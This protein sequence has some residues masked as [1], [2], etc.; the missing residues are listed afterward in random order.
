MRKQCCGGEK[1]KPWVKTHK[2]GSEQHK[3]EGEQKVGEGL[4]RKEFSGSNKQ[5]SSQ[6]WFEGSI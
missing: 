2:V 3:T 1:G 4:K 6:A 5:G